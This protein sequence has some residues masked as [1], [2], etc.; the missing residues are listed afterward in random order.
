MIKILII[1]PD[2]QHFVREF[3]DNALI[4]EEYEITFFTIRKNPDDIEHY[5]E[6]GISNISIK[7]KDGNLFQNADSVI[8][9]WLW[10]KKNAN[11]FDIIHIHFM[12]ARFLKFCKL[13]LKSHS[14]LIITFW[15][16]DLL[17]DAA[18]N[19]QTVSCFYPW[20]KKAYAINLMEEHSLDVFKQLFP[21]IDVN[22]VRV[23]DFGDSL[24]TLI[25]RE[26]SD[27]GRDGAKRKFSFPTDKIIVHVG[28]NGSAAHQHLKLLESLKPLDSEIK[29]K[30]FLVMHFGYGIGGYGY[31]EN[32]YIDAVKKKATDIG[33]EYRLLT[34]YLSGAKLADFRL[35]ADIMLYGQ[36]TDAISS[37]VVETVYAGGLFINPTWLDY[38]EFKEYGIKFLEYDK[39]EEIPSIV[40]KIVNEG[41][42]T[43]KEVLSNKKNIW[44]NKSWELLAP[45]WREMY[46]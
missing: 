28:H 20:L 18:N 25:K 11:K 19:K 29:E 42:L 43:S 21:I 7:R 16:S 23:V 17:R 45:K 33:I 24:L 14:K 37:S 22:K 10:L 40:S 15:G 41:T 27:I 2:S 35:T 6:Y 38:S 3:I 4:K 46:D 1:S 26:E 32:E 34:D 13:L 8:A 36:I 39:F 44:A 9:G 5:S 30:L 31:S 12:D